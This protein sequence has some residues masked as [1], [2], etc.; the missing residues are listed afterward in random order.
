MLIF[1]RPFLPSQVVR[2]EAAVVV[3]CADVL[4]VAPPLVPWKE[5][6]AAPLATLPGIENVAFPSEPTLP[7][8]D[9]TWMTL[10][11]EV[12]LGDVVHLVVKGPVAEL[13]PARARQPFSPVVRVVVSVP[14][15]VALVMVTPSLVVQP[16]SVALIS[17]LPDPAVSLA[18]TAG[19]N[20]AVPE[21]PV[22]LTVALVAFTLG[23]AFA[24]HV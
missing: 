14:E 15:A 17:V 10:L 8:I 9:L 24:N 19:L 23:A 3:V 16:V 1:E 2:I 21:M 20:E 22:Q 12:S 4:S 18:V 11:P 13:P 5:P 7:A 6:E